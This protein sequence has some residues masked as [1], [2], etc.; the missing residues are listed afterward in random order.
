MS[1]TKL[2]V[3]ALAMLVL[4]GAM[5]LKSAVTSHDSGAVIMANGSAPT[6]PTPWKNGSAPTPPS[7]FRNGG[8]PTPPSPFRNGGAPTPPSPFSK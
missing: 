6:P 2:G 7:P 3:V 5:G 4:V 1:P 8:A